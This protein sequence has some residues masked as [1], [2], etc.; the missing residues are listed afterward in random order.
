M[1]QTANFDKKP[2]SLR[3]YQDGVPC[4][5]LAHWRLSINGLVRNELHL[6][7]E[8]ILALPQTEESRRMV[9]VCNWSIRRPWK[10]VLLADVIR[11]VGVEQPEALYLRQISI[12]TPEKGVYEATIPLGQALDHSA[13]LIH[14]LDNGPLPPEQGFPLRLFDFALYGYKNVKGLQTLE[15]TDRYELGEWEERAG[16]SL[17]G[18][19]RPKK[20]WM[21]DLA[22]FGV[23]RRPG[24]I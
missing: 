14:S 21:V 5:D 19:I 20:Y 4:V 18:T 11:L 1:E 6:S 22:K 12:G 2:T 16:Y 7:Y 3:Y 9:C 8:D 17:D 24:E 15:I 13:L 10:G 23:A